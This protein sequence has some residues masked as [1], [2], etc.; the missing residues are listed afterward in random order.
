[1]SAFL[2]RK[3]LLQLCLIKRSRTWMCHSTFAFG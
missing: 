3:L 2:I 1:M